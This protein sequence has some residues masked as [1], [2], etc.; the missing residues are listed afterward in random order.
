[1]NDISKTFANMREKWQA[2]I[3]AR[4]EIREFSGGA[5][6]E[7][8]MANL[9]SA[10][11]GPTGRFRCG[12]KIVY[13]VAELVAWLESRSAVIPERR[14]ANDSAR[15]DRWRLV[16]SS[17]GRQCCTTRRRNFSGRMPSATRPKRND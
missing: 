12:R 6:S 4:T 5:L 2:P 8:Y 13:P 10:G 14:P 11:M 16:R 1:M 9:D 15:A 17:T 7:K 3:V